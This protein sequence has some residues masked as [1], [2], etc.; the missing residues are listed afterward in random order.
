[1]SLKGLVVGTILKVGTR[2]VPTTLDP[3]DI[4]HS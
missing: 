3:M 2:L 1:M 4:H